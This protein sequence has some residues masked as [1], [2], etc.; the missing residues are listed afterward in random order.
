MLPYRI[1][2][3]DER[4]EPVRE[5]ALEFDHDDDAID[6]AGAL[7]HPHAIDL[8]QGERHVARFPPWSSPLRR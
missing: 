7:K 3:L 1:R 8:W 6:H 4:G 2:L 5:H